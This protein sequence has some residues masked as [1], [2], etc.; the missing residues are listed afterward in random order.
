MMNPYRPFTRAAMWAYER[1]LPHQTMDVCAE[2]M[3]QCI[4]TIDLSATLTT[5]ARLR[6][7]RRSMAGS[8]VV[9]HSRR[10]EL[11]IA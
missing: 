11:D 6:A 9:Q 5:T 2:F 3:L 7:P 8:Q 1:A 10:G 4:Q